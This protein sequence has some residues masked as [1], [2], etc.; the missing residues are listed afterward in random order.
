MLKLPMKILAYHGG[1]YEDYSLLGCDV[2]LYN[3]SDHLQ[4]S[5]QLAAYI[6]RLD[7]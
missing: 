3:M 5:E 6:F 2:M 7:E 4:Y 1:D